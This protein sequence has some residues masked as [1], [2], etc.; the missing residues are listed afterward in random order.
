MRK[1]T[2]VV[3]VLVLLFSMVQAGVVTSFAEQSD[4]PY[5]ETTGKTMLVFGDSI[6]ASTNITYDTDANGNLNCTYDEDGNPIYNGNF[7]YTHLEG[8]RKW[9]DYTAETLHIGKLWNFAKSGGQFEDTRYASGQLQLSQQVYLALTQDIYPDIVVISMGTNDRDSYSRVTL[10]ED[11]V[12]GAT[13]VEI[14]KFYYYASD[15]TDTTSGTYYMFDGTD[16]TANKLPADYIVGTTYY[17]RTPS[18]KSADVTSD[19]VGTY[20]IANSHSFGTFEEA[21]SKDIAD[22]DRTKIYEALRWAMYMIK[23][24]Y[25]DAYCFIATPIPTFLEEMP[26]KII[27]AIES[28]AEQYDFTVIPALDE[29]GI[30]RELEPGLYLKDDGLHPNT[31]GRQQMSKIYTDIISRTVNLPFNDVSG[32]WYEQY[33][34]KVFRKGLMTGISS[35]EFAGD[36]NLTRAMFVTAL[37]HLDQEFNKASYTTSSFTDVSTNAWYAPYVAWGVEKGLVSGTAPGIFSPDDNITREQMALIMYKMAVNLK[38]DV[39][40]EDPLTGY[41]DADSISGWVLTAVKWAVNA[42]LISGT[43]DITISPLFNATR[44]QVATILSAFLSLCGK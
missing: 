36:S 38:L 27:N 26:D 29:S 37:S 18:Y 33:V 39:T 35:E 20:Y 34:R 42:K 23:K 17:S 5:T 11:Y 1:I 44:A 13:Y 21:M 4:Y 3:L 2:S 22:L 12:E 28:M 32:K 41:T 14:D 43:S 16:Y 6:T 10:P 15:V 31:S 40:E 30:E 24:N 25:P 7:E 9:A 8:S 19:T